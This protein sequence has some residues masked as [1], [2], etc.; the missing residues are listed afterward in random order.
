ME[1]KEKHEM[2]NPGH[3][4]QG[5]KFQEIKVQFHCWKEREKASILRG[6]MHEIRTISEMLAA[7][8][9]EL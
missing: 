4:F 8:I 3:S 2:E 9:R 1:D 6:N 7:E 5:C